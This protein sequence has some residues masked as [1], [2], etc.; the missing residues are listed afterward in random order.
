[1]KRFIQYQTDRLSAIPNMASAI[2]KKISEFQFDYRK[3]L[4]EASVFFESHYEY[5]AE[6][7]QIKKKNTAYQEHIDIVENYKK[8]KGKLPIIKGQRS[9]Q[10]YLEKLHQKID[11]GEL[12]IKQIAT[13]RLKARGERYIALEKLID[14]ILDLLDG[15]KIFSQFLGTM[16]LSTPLPNETVRCTRNEKNKPIYITALT[17]ALFEETRLF[18]QYKSPYLKQALSDVIGDDKVSLM[19]RH[20]HKPFSKEQ[21]MAYREEVLKPIVKATLLRHIGSYSP[22]AEAIYQGN[23]FRLLDVEERNKLLSSIKRHSYLYLSQ[24]VGLPQKRFD[25]KE[26]RDEFF[27]VENAK[28]EFMKQ[29]LDFDNQ[30]PELRDL[31]RIPMVYASFMLSTKEE[32]DYRNMYRAYDIL[33]DGMKQG[34]YNANFCA[35]FLRMVGRFPLGS[36]IYFISNDTEQ[37]EKGIVSSLFPKN[38]EEPYVKQITRN[39]IQSLSQSEVL[40]VRSTNIY[41]DSTRENSG[42]DEAIFTQRYQPPYVWNA[43]EVWEVQVPALVFWKK[44]GT[45]KQSNLSQI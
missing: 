27:A 12:R 29:L 10:R 26:E 37:I 36:G 14:N 31:I 34:E 40:V 9:A 24:G 25:K 19:Q 5:E 44:D 8:E 7:A 39:H 45:I 28:L 43:N 6:L 1:M 23:R 33:K 15:P 32:Y 21:K 16:V 2:S 11:K 18:Y 20:D 42:V 17:V 38:S 35:L 22:H 4:E 41:F 13:E 3:M 30:G